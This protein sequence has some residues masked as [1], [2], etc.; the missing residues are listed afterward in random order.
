MNRKN[1]A[2]ERFKVFILAILLFSPTGF[3]QF[4]DRIMVESRTIKI[5]PGWNMVSIPFDTKVSMDEF[6]SKCGT[7][8][9][10]WRLHQSGYSKE[11]VLV[12]GVGYWIKGTR[13]CLFTLS[14]IPSN[15]VQNLF[16]GWNLVA[17]PYSAVSASDYA[18]NCKILSGPWHYNP[19]LAGNSNPYTY[20]SALEPGK[21]YWIRVESSCRMGVKEEPPF[22]P[23]ENLAPVITSVSGPS[24]L[25]VGEQGTWS[26]SAYDPEGKQLTYSFLWGDENPKIATPSSVL[27]TATATHIYYVPG[28]YTVRITVTDEQGASSQA[29]AT[30]YVSSV[31]CQ[32]FVTCAPGYSPVFSHIGKE[33]CPVFICK[34]STQQVNPKT[35]AQ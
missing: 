1:Q 27:Q 22:P 26:I 33:G 23:Q 16:A 8:P 31:N 30:V 7:S 25:K 2:I 28:N 19:N 17:A 4:E 6:V 11:Q 34:P 9:N 5:S 12:P 13:E 24:Q 10:A 29:S 35:V 20:S 15:P 14:G 21:A 3:A 32:T 18:G